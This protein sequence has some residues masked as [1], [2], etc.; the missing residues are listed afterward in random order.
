MT[1]RFKIEVTRED[2]VLVD[3]A[4][5]VSFTL[6]STFGANDVALEILETLDE[7]LAARWASTLDRHDT[8]YVAQMLDGNDLVSERCVRNPK[9]RQE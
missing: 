5:D 7:V 2:A 4:T 3:Q 9:W 6:T 1:K 8:P